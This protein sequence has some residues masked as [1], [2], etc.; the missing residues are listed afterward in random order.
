MT[1]YRHPDGSY[2]RFPHREEP[3][4]AMTPI[5]GRPNWWRDS[6]GVEHYVEP[7]RPVQGG[8]P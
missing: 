7:P 2:H 3:Q 8:K 6:N 5:A 4:K 1:I